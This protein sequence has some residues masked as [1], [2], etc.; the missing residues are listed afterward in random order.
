LPRSAASSSLQFSM[1]P[2]A[3]TNLSATSVARRPSR[4]ASETEAI[5]RRS[6]SVAKPVAFACR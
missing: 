6:G 2:V 4:L 1:P 5:R 3:S